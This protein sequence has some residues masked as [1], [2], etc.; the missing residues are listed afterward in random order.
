MRTTFSDQANAVSHQSALI[1]CA[2][3]VFMERLAASRTWIVRRP[4][5]A[6]TGGRGDWPLKLET[7]C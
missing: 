2:L 4:S 6:V 3:L 7:Y 5:S 1:D